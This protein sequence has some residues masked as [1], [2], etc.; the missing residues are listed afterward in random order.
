MFVWTIRD[1]AMKAVAIDQIQK[2]LSST[3]AHGGN[4]MIFKDADLSGKSN[5]VPNKPSLS[6][7]HCNKIF[8]A[9]KLEGGSDKVWK[10]IVHS[11]KNFL[12]GGEGKRTQL[13]M[14]SAL[15]DFQQYFS[16]LTLTDEQRHNFKSKVKN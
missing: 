11:C 4:V 15:D 8:Q 3:G 16:K 9:S 5:S 7:A 6:G 1:E 12:S 13:E 14:W 2:V 10:D